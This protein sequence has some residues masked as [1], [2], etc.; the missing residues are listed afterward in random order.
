MQTF[1]PYHS[2]IDSLVILDNKRLGKQR[3]EGMQILKVLTTPHRSSRA[4]VNHPATRMWR[5]YER[6]LLF[7][8]RAACDIWQLRGFKNNMEATL[9]NIARDIPESSKFE[10]PDYFD[11]EFHLSHQSNLIRKDPM[12]YGQFFPHVPG[13]LPYKWPV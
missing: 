1:L 8:T 12:H 13:N 9:D 7:Y 6:A 3:V 5:G 2:V 4:W 10:L 11:E